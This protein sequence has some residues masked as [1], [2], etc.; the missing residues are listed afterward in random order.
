MNSVSINRFSFE[1][2]MGGLFI[3]NHKPHLSFLFFSGA[4]SGEVRRIAISAISVRDLAC[5]SDAAPLKNKRT[6]WAS[7]V[8]KQA[9]PPGF[10]RHSGANRMRF[11]VAYEF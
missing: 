4:A 2:R 3:G 8:Y 1:P 9:T 10:G 7:S 5:W 11:G 6:F